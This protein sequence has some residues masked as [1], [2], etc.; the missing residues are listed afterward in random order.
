MKR[1]RDSAIVHLFVSTPCRLSEI[2]LLDLEGVDVRERQL[3]IVRKGRRPGT[4]PFGPTAAQAL[5]RYLR[6]RRKHLRASSPKF[7]LGTKG[8]MTPSGLRQMLERRCIEAG[9]PHM[10]WHQFRHT[11][12]HEWLRGGG[13]EGDLMALAGWKSRAMLARYGR[14]LA[15]QRAH[16]AYAER[17][18][19]E[20]L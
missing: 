2:A 4:V 7:W 12:S 3:Q 16:D 13:S 5:D 15:E 11:F 10:H 14:A 20:R 19:G 8:A 6:A 1:R 18:P 17:L 9:L